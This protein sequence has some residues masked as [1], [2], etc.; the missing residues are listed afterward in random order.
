MHFFIEA[1]TADELPGVIDLPDIV[2]IRPSHRG[3]CRGG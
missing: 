2:G 3:K 1:R